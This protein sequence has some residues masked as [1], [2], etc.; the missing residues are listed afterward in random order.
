MRLTLFPSF[1]VCVCVCVCVC[2]F[3][4][5]NSESNTDFTNELFSSGFMFLGC[6][7]ELSRKIP[8]SGAFFWGKSHDSLLPQTGL[9]VSP[10]WQVTWAS[11]FR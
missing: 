7:A 8:V 1:T 5:M 3:I 4:E 2:V 6:M 11:V 10:N 9:S